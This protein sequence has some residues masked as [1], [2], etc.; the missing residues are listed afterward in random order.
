MAR[1]RQARRCS[2]RRTDGQPCRAYAVLGGEMCA[3]HGGSAPQV[4]DSALTRYWSGRLRY[5]YDTAYRRWRREVFDW[6][7][8]R[9]LAAAGI[10]GICPSAVTGFQLGWLAADG[11]IASEATMPK[12]RVDRRYGPRT[13][14][15][16]AARAARQAARKAGERPRPSDRSPSG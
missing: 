8:Q 6:Q 2:A 10:L 3:A 4:R 1:K 14:A 15:Q 5:A 11:Q 13:R 16:L 9:V 12:I 7:V